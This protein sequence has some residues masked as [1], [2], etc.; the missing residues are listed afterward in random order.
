VAA[1]VAAAELDL[2]VITVTGAWPGPGRGGGADAFHRRVAM[3]ASR[4]IAVPDG[5]TERAWIQ[6]GGDP[7][8]LVVTG[9]PVCDTVARIRRGY[10]D[11]IRPLPE[12]SRAVVL[13][14]SHL[15]RPATRDAV[16]RT[17]QE[18]VARHPDVEVVCPL[19]R[20]LDDAVSL[21]RA[22]D[23]IER[24]R[25]S[26]A[27][28]YPIFL[29]LLTRADLVIT[30]AEGVIEEAAAIGLPVLV[31]AP[32]TARRSILDVG[33]G[34]LVGPDAG[35]TVAEASLILRDAEHAGA[36]RTAWTPFAAEGAA[37]R[38]AAE[39]L[40]WAEAAGPRPAPALVPVRR[41][42]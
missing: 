9:S 16:V 14:L 33:A 25:V 32:D 36:M 7:R 23:G 38:V 2:P 34:R 10:P 15:D 21:R 11:G 29:D 26:P 39:I 28:E 5:S 1:H 35:R 3:V 17:V 13:A 6:A 27:L 19:P 41:A 4:L 18:L 12:G 31:T 24:V 20:S 37:A 42:A 8:R 30:D 22:L 40:G